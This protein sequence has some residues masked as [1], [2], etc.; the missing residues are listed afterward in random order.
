MALLNTGTK[1]VGNPSTKFKDPKANILY[2]GG[3]QQ[4]SSKDI[5]D[6]LYANQNMS[7]QEIEGNALAR[8]IS[9]NQIE[10]A[11]KGNNDFIGKM[12]KYLDENV[13][14]ELNQQ[15]IPQAALPAKV[16]PSAIKVGTNETVEGRMAGLL[17]DP[18]N[19]L[20]VQAQTFA[21][22]Q[23]NKR[24]LLNSSINTSAAQ[25]A[26]MKNVMPIAQQDAATFYDANK[27]NVGNDMSSQMFNSDQQGRIGMFNAGTAKD[28]ALTDKNN[29]AQ[30]D[31]QKMNRDFDMAVARMDSDN[32]LAVANIQ[33]MANDSGIAG[34][35]GKS[36]MSMYQQTA[37]D[38][39]LST[40]AKASIYSNL[41]SQYE[42]VVSLL[43]SIKL[44]AQ[45][46]NFPAAS[47]STG[48]PSKPSEAGTNTTSNTP[49]STGVQS[50]TLPA[51]L[52]NA[53]NKVNVFG[54]TVEPDVRAMAVAYERQTGTKVD[55]A[56]LVPKSF[57]SG[58]MQANTAGADPYGP[59][60]LVSWSKLANDLFGSPRVDQLGKLI[61][62]VHPPKTMRADSPL[63]YVWNQEELAKLK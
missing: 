15:P 17:K 38:P 51:N 21:N 57:A 5:S 39:N 36:L 30:F 19:P 58:I 40:E 13:S 14:K 35:L 23:T 31:I 62:P 56:L 16:K 24:G 27:T 54:M 20:N 43:P 34:D 52:A 28:F 22:Q 8:G 1:I 49:L 48:N 44:K 42:S 9:R 59:I 45:S 11:M 60:P 50:S 10:Q 41:K 25:D 46:L 55:P 29:Q 6:F 4:Y 53:I 47:G 37:A 12:D 7:A 61:L 33:A 3:N 63:F 18:N 2:G 32:K 26:M